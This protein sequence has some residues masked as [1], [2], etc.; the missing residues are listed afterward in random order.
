VRIFLLV[1]LLLALPLSGAARPR[2]SGGTGTLE[3]NSMTA[4]AT[5]FID[6]KEVGALPLPG[7]L[8]LRV[9][10]HTLKIAKRGY[11][12]FLDVIT[13][14]RG[15]PTSLDIDLLP[16]AGIVR[17]TSNIPGARV[18]VDGKFEGTTP[19]ERE[20]LI[21]KRTIRVT[22]A[23]YYD[24]IATVKSRAGLEKRLRVTLRML[25]IGSTPYRPKPP[26]PARWYEKWYVWAGV[27]GALAVVAVAVAV[28]VAMA[29]KNRVDDWQ[30]D[31]RYTAR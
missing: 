15:K 28:P 8:P 1:V 25:P 23:G 19:L 29:G 4:G 2:A 6:G 16:Y 21:G 14:K 17:I 13:I 22:K 9:G 3:L 12:E 31:I 26:P 11:T 5:V 27:A 24:F 7:P 20:L 30:P 18:F 10:Q